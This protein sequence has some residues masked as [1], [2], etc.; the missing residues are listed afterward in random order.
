MKMQNFHERHLM[1]EYHQLFDQLKTAK[2]GS[3]SRNE[4]L[5]EHCSWRIGGPADILVEPHSGPRLQKILRITGDYNVPVVIIGCGTNLLFD[6]AGVRGVVVKIGERMAGISITGTH[7]RAGAGTWMPRLARAVGRAG[8]SGLE[9]TIGIPGTLGGL[10]VMNGGSLHQSLGENVR[11]LTIL[12]RQG[13]SDLFSHQNCQFS[14]RS[15][16]MQKEGLIVTEVELECER[17][18]KS[19]IRREMLEILRERDRK[20]PRKTPNCGSV[21]LSSDELYERFG[22][23]GKIIEETGLKGLSV[24]DARVS[25]KHANFMINR[26]GA[27]SADVLELIRRVRQAVY[28]RIGIQLNCEVRYVSPNGSIMP[29]HLAKA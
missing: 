1:K 3:L 15:S 14:Y 22:P 17:A 25:T 10:V 24:G 4:P 20:F 5:R 29:A 18:P 2:V 19:V 21:F 16:L 13:R 11:H 12:D 7:I 6:D 23:A 8:L 9:H 28:N 27:G 26:G